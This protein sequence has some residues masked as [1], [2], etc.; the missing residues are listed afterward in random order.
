MNATET[1]RQQSLAKE[2][3]ASYHQLTLLYAWKDLSDLMDRIVQESNRQVDTCPTE[4]LIV[5]VVAEARGFRKAV[6]KIRK[7][8]DFAM[9]GGMR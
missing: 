1:D 2:L 7:H 3:A 4:N 5:A 6:D 9:N 8:M